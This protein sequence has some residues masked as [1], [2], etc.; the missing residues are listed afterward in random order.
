LDFFLGQDRKRREVSRDIGAV[1]RRKYS[2]EALFAR[3]LPKA[4][5]RI[6]KH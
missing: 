3:T 4:L 1:V 2:A 5:E 6:K